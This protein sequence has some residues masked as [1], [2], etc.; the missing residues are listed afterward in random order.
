ML[1][2]VPNKL[3]PIENNNNGKCQKKN[4]TFFFYNK[5]INIKYLKSTYKTRLFFASKM[6]GWN[7]SMFELF[8]HYTGCHKEILYTNLDEYSFLF[9][10]SF[11]KYYDSYFSLNWYLLF[12]KE[13]SVVLPLLSRGQRYIKK[14]PSRGQRTR[15]NY[16]TNKQRREKLSYKLFQKRLTNAYKTKHF[17]NWKN[18]D[19]FYFHKY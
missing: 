4:I 14:L 5:K 11:L 18:M 16:E 1:K 9:L 12:L 15:S 3:I 2:Y 13:R 17:P 7:K 19:F 10:K 6:F 8:F